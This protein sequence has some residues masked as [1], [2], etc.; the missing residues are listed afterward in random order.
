MLF[1]LL[2]HAVLTISYRNNLL[3]LL[4][5]EYQSGALAI[6]CRCVSERLKIKVWTRNYSYV[7]GICV[8]YLVAFD[9]HWNLV[10]LTPINFTCCC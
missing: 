7:R 1:L 8:G 2:H 10:W 9:K 5:D 4:A 6:L 3:L